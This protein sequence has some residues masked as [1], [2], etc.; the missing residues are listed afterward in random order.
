MQLEV[1]WPGYKISQRPTVSLRQIGTLARHQADDGGC[2][3]G[4]ESAETQ[5][6]AHQPHT[7]RLYM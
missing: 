5:H 3:Y 6:Q 7:G 2:I 4:K 1:Q